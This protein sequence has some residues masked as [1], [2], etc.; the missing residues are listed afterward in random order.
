MQLA[1][2]VRAPCPTA[3]GSLEVG[4]MPENVV[5]LQWMSSFPIETGI[6]VERGTGALAA[7]GYEVV[8]SLPAGSTEYEDEPPVL[9][10]TYW[11]RL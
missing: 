9:G 1:E 6:E 4:A 3:P 2:G 7:S 11:Y 5:R 8:V 10:E